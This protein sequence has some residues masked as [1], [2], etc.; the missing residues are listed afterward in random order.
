M[1]TFRLLLAD[2]PFRL[3]NDEVLFNR[4]RTQ[5]FARPNGWN[6]L[7]PECRAFIEALLQ[8]ASSKRPTIAKVLSHP[9][10]SQ[11]KQGA[12][13]SIPR[14]KEYLEAQASGR[15]S[16]QASGDDGDGDDVE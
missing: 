6:A 8:K 14:L 13:K 15:N 11:P 10:L 2:Y 3:D 7:S 16:K 1:I 12:G 9:W 4:I 5:D